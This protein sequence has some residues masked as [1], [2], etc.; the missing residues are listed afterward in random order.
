MTQIRL[1]G[2]LLGC[3]WF[4]DRWGDKKWH[5]SVF[6]SSNSPVL[7]IGSSLL[8]SQSI[9][10]AR[11]SRIPSLAARKSRNQS[12]KSCSQNQNQRA[13]PHVPARSE[14]FV[15]IAYPMLETHFRSTKP[16]VWG[17][18]HQNW[19]AG[20][21]I[22]GHIQACPNRYLAQKRRLLCKN[23]SGQSKPATGFLSQYACRNVLFNRIDLYIYIH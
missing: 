5:I 3:R 13:V 9:E 10:R 19:L 8:R 16:I 11:M 21:H 6:G 23:K 18:H 20:D 17:G 12:D 2:L 1:Y 22:Q 7:F 15:Q 14:I 4:P